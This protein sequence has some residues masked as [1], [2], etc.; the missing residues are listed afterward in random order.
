MGRRVAT[1]V[2]IDHDA[3]VVH[4]YIS[5]HGERDKG[6][7]GLDSECW[8]EMGETAVYVSEKMVV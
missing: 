8:Q 4:G 7:K 6:E 1:R 3:D 5:G 2:L